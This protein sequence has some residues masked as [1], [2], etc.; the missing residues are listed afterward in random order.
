MEKDE[1]GL[2]RTK[3]MNKDIPKILWLYLPITVA[4]LPYLARLIGA[5][6]DR[7]IYG[8]MGLIE[9]FTVLFLL[10]AI[11]FCILFLIF[12][13]NLRI[14]R[15][16]MLNYWILLYLL[17]CV[18]YLGEEISWGQHYFG[19]ATPESWSLVNDQQE[20]NI[21]NTSA[22]FDQI[23]RA[24]LSTAALLGGVLVPFINWIKNKKFN[25]SS[26]NY[27][28][29]PTYICIPSALL[30]L[31]VSWFEK[32]FEILNIEMPLF[33]N[34]RAGETKEC[35]LALFIMMYVLSMWYRNRKH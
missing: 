31:L 3:L 6:T 13:K 20:T 28:I 26:I 15:P 23:P 30:S 14:T 18:Y 29:W 4:I 11:L 8:E 2:V 17:G 34:I 24:I 16:T 9:N 12:S 35:L 5:Q 27:W 21:H 25:P 7:F 19:W 33:L 22:I 10:I 1:Y 32:S